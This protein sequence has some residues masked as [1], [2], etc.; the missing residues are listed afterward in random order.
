MVH[1]VLIQ[2]F[3]PISAMFMVYLHGFEGTFMV[4]EYGRHIGCGFMT[5]VLMLM[6]LIISPFFHFFFPFLVFFCLLD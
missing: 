3:G 4:L 5:T 2:H 1:S 6:V